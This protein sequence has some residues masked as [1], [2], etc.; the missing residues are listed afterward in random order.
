V[1]NQYSE[2]QQNRHDQNSIRYHNWSPN[3]LITPSGISPAK[4]IHDYF[5]RKYLMITWFHTT[6]FPLK[7]HLL[8]NSRNRSKVKRRNGIYKT[9]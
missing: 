6:V 2:F 4:N 7:Q 1:W 5:S 8:V 9:F 3:T